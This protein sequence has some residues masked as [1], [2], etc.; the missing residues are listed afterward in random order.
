V[1][2][3]TVSVGFAGAGQIIGQYVVDSASRILWPAGNTAPASLSWIRT[4]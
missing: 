4:W 1:P 3:N 2:P